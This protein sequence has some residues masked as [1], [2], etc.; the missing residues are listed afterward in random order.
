MIILV[1]NSPSYNKRK[2]S[3]DSK[4]IANTNCNGCSRNRIYTTRVANIFFLLTN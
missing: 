3:D 2:K 1:L 4:H